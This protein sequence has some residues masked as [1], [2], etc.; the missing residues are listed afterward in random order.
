MSRCQNKL[1]K[2]GDVYK[3][4]KISM[5]CYL[6]TYLR[7]WALL[8]GSSIVQ[9]LKKFPAF[10]GTRRFNAVFTR[11]LHWSLSWAISI[12][13]T[14]SHPISHVSKLKSPTNSL[15]TA[16]LP[17]FS[18]VCWMVREMKYTNKCE[19]HIN[20][21]FMYWVLRMLKNFFLS[22]IWLSV[23][24]HQHHQWGWGPKVSH[25]ALLFVVLNDYWWEGWSPELQQLTTAPVAALHNKHHSHARP[26]QW[27]L[28]KH[29][30]SCRAVTTDL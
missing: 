23:I 22:S 20:I 29:L 30:D 12:Q 24:T 11:A 3:Y 14:P 9:P 18:E 25:L 21:H 6:L 1:Y 10:Y 7:S 28:H 8:E 4:S 19:L 26:E 17:K 13:S 2:W 16:L 5:Y 15:F 27:Y